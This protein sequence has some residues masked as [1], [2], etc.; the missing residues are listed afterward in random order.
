MAEWSGTRVL[1]REDVVQSILRVRVIGQSLQ[2]AA[3]KTEQRFD[4]AGSVIGFDG[5]PDGQVRELFEPDPFGRPKGSAGFVIQKAKSGEISLRPV[6]PK[7]VLARL[8][9]ADV[10]SPEGDVESGE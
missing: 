10:D 4:E 1:V 9:D 6:E 2:E 5:V 3:D 7:D 8:R